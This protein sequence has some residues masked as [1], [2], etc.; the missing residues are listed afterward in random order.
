MKK[1]F[2]S[3]I[4]VLFTVVASLSICL[5]CWAFFTSRS[6]RKN[7]KINYVSLLDNN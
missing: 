7:R 4:L 2:A 3:R 5:A 6:Y 1:L